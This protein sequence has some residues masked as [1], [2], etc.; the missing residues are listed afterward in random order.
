MTQTAS[1]PAE[2]PGLPDGT[3][4]NTVDLDQQDRGAQ[5]TRGEGDMPVSPPDAADSGASAVDVLVRQIRQFIQDRHLCVGDALPS[6]REL[7][8][9]FDAA[10]NTVR[11]AIRILKTYGVIDVRPKVGAVIADRHMDAVFDLFSF[12]LTMT[13]ETFLDIQGFRRLIEVGCVDALLRGLTDERL[14]TLEAINV[15]I[16]QAGS[17]EA[18]A[19]CDFEFH[20]TML[21]Y[22]GNRTLVG[23]Y[24][25]MQPMITRLMETGKA[26]DGLEGTFET[27]SLI[28]DALRR[29][30][31][32]AF[33]Y[34][35]DRHL[36]HGLRFVDGSVD[37]SDRAA[38]HGSAATIGTTGRRSSTQREDHHET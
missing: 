29:R 17:V 23:V 12:Q 32:L 13:R 15:G 31:R 24:R 20:R 27:H 21:S 6:E 3:N 8:E 34:L 9:R 19:Q 25:S 11:E 28:L 4:R 14:A 16:L 35:M 30:D 26:T 37:Q 18:A 10:R 36:D 5:T 2:N 22:A 38:A 7:G 33:Q 1:F